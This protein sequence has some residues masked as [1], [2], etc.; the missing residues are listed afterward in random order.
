MSLKK[1]PVESIR[2]IYNDKCQ[3]EEQLCAYVVRNRVN[4]NDRVYLHSIE[5]VLGLGVKLRGFES[6]STGTTSATGNTSAPWKTVYQFFKGHGK[7]SI[8]ISTFEPFPGEIIF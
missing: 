5:P 3:A 7:N 1:R 6:P 2:P 8:K 4:W